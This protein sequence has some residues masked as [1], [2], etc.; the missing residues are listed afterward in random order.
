MNKSYSLNKKII[1]AIERIY[2]KKET[3]SF[4]HDIDRF[5]DEGAALVQ[6]IISDQHIE[7]LQEIKTKYPNIKV[8]AG[9]NIDSI[10]KASKYLDGQAD[11]IV[12]G[13]FLAKNPDLVK[14]WIKLF[15]Q[16]LIVSIDDKGG[17]LAN[18]AKIR[19]KVYARLLEK[20]KVKNVIYVSENTKL[21]GGINLNGFKSVRDIVKNTTIIYSGGV[22]S[23]D[24]LR[25]LKK[26]CADSVIVGTAL[27]HKK[28]KYAEAK[29]AFCN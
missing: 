14:N 16:R 17:V 19:T 3:D 28:F 13:R 8:I 24:D 1:P 2:F 20:N 9:G 15:S 6:L 29:G 7:I 5:S 11:Y 26:A 27:Y 23:L 12:V 4:I 18:N 25:I 21:V 10:K 22:S